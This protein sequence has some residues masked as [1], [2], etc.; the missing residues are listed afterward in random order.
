VIRRRFS[1]RDTKWV[2]FEYLVFTK[3]PRQ[4]F[5]VC[6]WWMADGC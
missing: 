1:S 3:A 2:G 4:T 6:G 5:P